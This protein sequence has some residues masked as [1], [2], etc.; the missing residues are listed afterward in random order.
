MVIGLAPVFA[1][2]RGKASYYSKRATGAKTSDGSRLHHD[3]LTCAHRTYP[4]GT[5]LKVTNINNGKSVIVK[6]NDRGPHSRGRVI[7]LTYRAAKEIGMVAQG[8]AMVE[9]EEYEETIVPLR[10][11]DKYHP[12]EFQTADIQPDAMHPQWE[13]SNSN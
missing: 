8:I 3:S 10:P 9:I 6:V 4:F 12:I 7:D 11:S 2:Q 1:Q 5:L 13:R